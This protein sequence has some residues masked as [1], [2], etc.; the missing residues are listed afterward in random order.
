MSIPTNNQ[1]KYMGGVNIVW[2]VI[3]SWT[4]INLIDWLPWF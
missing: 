2:T 1:P 4:V 3:K